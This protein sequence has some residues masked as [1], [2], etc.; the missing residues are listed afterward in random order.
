MGHQGIERNLSLLRQRCFWGGMYEDVEQWVKKCQRC[1]LAKMPQPKIKAPWA[2]FLASRPLEVVAVD[3][4]TLEPATDGREN[5]LVVTD[6][7]TKFSQAF[8]TRDQKAETTAKILLREW[9]LK[10]GVPQ[11]LH[12]DQGRNFESMGTHRTIC[13]LD[14]LLGQEPV[15]DEKLD[16][17][18]V[19]QERLRDAH[20]R[21]KE[22]AERKAVE[23]AR[24]HEDKVYCPAIEVGQHVYL[25]HRPPG[26]NK[27]QVAWS[28]TV[29]R[30]L[31]T[32][33]LSCPSTLPGTSWR[34]C[35]VEN[36]TATP[37][38][39]PGDL[40]VDQV[41]SG[42]SNDSS[43][44]ESQEI[45]NDTP[46]VTPV[47]VVL[48]REESNLL[49]ENPMMR[50][51][52]APRKKKEESVKSAVP[53]PSERRTQRTSAGVHSNPNRLPKSACNA[54]SFS[55]D[56]LSQVLAGMVLYTTG[57]LQGALDD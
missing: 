44:A 40:S 37:V 11:R 33:Q 45:L 50:P 31:E 56:V 51:V 25:R 30:V 57:R 27:I 9:F 19:H 17:L 46:E 3:F 54:V 36:P 43:G 48:E 41:E 39:E 18:K 16:W 42:R 24:Q 49:V 6:V 7:F 34:M 21:A 8:P 14:A 2:S 13:A 20:A 23:R 1:M 53:C 4:T 29:Y 15:T 38:S 52:P 26:R 5:V 22:Y 10:Y 28:S 12:S 32:L 35:S 47:S 55:P